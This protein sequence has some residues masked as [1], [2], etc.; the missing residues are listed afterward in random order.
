MRTTLVRKFWNSNLITVKKDLNFR[1]LYSTV[2]K[3]SMM[4]T[5]TPAKKKLVKAFSDARNI[6]LEEMGPI[7]QQDNINDFKIM[8][9]DITERCL[10]NNICIFDFNNEYTWFS[11]K[12]MSNTR[13]LKISNR[14]KLTFILKIKKQYIV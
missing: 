12:F 8:C 13:T 10:S 1:I 7:L 11:Q 5:R 2:L 4:P 9:T 3:S 6:L 14:N